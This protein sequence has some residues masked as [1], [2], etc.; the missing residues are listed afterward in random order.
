MDLLYNSKLFA[1]GGGVDYTIDTDADEYHEK[2]GG[3]DPDTLSSKV[4]GGFN[5]S[6]LLDKVPFIISELTREC[7]KTGT[8][9]DTSKITGN[10]KIQ[11]LAKEQMSYWSKKSDGHWYIK[12]GT[13]EYRDDDYLSSNDNIFD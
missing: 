6:Y 5:I 4:S 13:M 2:T 8:A 12:H 9:P 11:E 3:G 7:K 1:L 10:I